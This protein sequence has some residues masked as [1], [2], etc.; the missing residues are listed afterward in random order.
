MNGSSGIV[1]LVGAGPGDPGLITVRG[2]DLLRQADVIVH[3]RL[4]GRELLAEV[5]PGAEV[6]DI[7]K[8]PRRRRVP[9]ERINALLVN[10]AR[11]GKMVVR[12]KGGDPCIFGRAFEEMTACR[13]AGVDYVVIPGVTSALAAPAAVG[14][15]VTSRH[16]VRSLAMITA[17]TAPDGT[18]PPLDYSALAGIDTV[19]VLMGRAKLREV[20]RSLIEAGREATTP[21]AC[22][23][24]ATTPRQRLAVGT[25]ET[26]ADV[27][28]RRGLCAP[29]VTVIGAAA[30]FARA[31]HRQP[32]TPLAGKR[33]LVPRPCPQYDELRRT[34]SAAGATT[35][36][37]L[38]AAIAYP[39]E[40]PRLDRS[41]RRLDRYSWLMFTSL[42]GV[43]G[44]WKRLNSARLDA[45]ALGSCKVAAAGP[46]TA[47][48]L[49][50][51]GIRAD[52]VTDESDCELLFAAMR[53][54]A[55]ANL[56]R[57]L[58]PCGAASNDLAGRRRFD[59]DFHVESAVAYR[60]SEVRPASPVRQLLDDGVDA[61][62]F[63]SSPAPGRSLRLGINPPDAII[64]CLGRRTAR[65]AQR[66]RLNVDVIA[67]EP[68]GL[69]KELSDC[70]SAAANRSPTDQLSPRKN[71]TGKQ[72]IDAVELT[73]QL[74]L[75][76]DKS[77]PPFVLAPQAK[78]SH[79]PVDAT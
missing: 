45:R 9:Q 42:H 15:P 57:V 76:D 58:Y 25:L 1:Y 56:G 34:L 23:E 74:A 21:A 17:Q 24:W 44:F 72:E 27:A 6:I 64:A 14:I 70:F 49:R 77:F 46:R 32:S 3:D 62:V 75:H 31:D 10:R 16:L 11:K 41:I 43:R 30:A 8:E 13:Q 29:V 78:S 53:D 79:I 68:S 5:R 35:I 33:I 37:C 40:A 36:S 2:F 51:R 19:C 38:T 54:A 4:I 52:I 63:G 22:I 69:I 48:E 7:G 65:A 55:P 67:E 66:E 73:G 60:V 61:V 50:R 20:A 47:G 12:L 26:I 18:A 39:D 71:R 28:D 59:A